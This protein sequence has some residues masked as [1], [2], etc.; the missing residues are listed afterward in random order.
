MGWRRRGVQRRWV[1]AIIV[2]AALSLAGCVGPLAGAGRTPSPTATVP[3]DA[4]LLRIVTDDTGAVSTQVPA[5]WSD[6]A[7]VGFTDDAGVVWRAV[8]AAPSLADFGESA[9][10]AGVQVMA[11]RGTGQSAETTF[12]A[13]SGTFDEACALTSQPAAYRD[14]VHVG[15]F[16]V[17]DCAGTDAVVVSV[18]NGARDNVVA[19]VQVA[20]DVERELGL[21]A[22]LSSFRARL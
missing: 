22:I 17:W 5:A 10:A 20:T 9:S 16:A 7:D 8:A 2:A 3:A 21:S 19:I 1:A 15:V 13:L 18:L 4:S 12:L 14:T 6:V 11:A